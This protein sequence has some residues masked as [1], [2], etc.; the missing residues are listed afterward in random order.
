MHKTLALVAALT[1]TKYPIGIYCSEG[2]K[3]YSKSNIFLQPT[4][5][6]KS[7]QAQCECQSREGENCRHSWAAQIPWG[8]VDLHGALGCKRTLRWWFSW[9]LGHRFSFWSM[10]SSQKL[11]S[12]NFIA[13]I[14]SDHIRTLSYFIFYLHHFSSVWIGNFF[15]TSQN[16]DGSP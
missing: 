14:A 5:L 16:S 11:H 7:Q 9:L 8:K 3:N 2:E 1:N 12:Y 10:I 4:C 15:L 6:S 13:K